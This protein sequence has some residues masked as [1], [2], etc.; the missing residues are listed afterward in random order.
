MRVIVI[1]AGIAGL[2]AA[3]TLRRRGIDVVVLEAAGSVGGRIQTATMKG[4]PVELGAQFLSTGYRVLPD[5]L[6]A[7]GLSSVP[8]SQ[9][10]AI[11]TGGRLRTITSTSTLSLFRSGLVS[12]ADVGAVARSSATLRRV[13]RLNRADLTS[14]ADHGGAAARAWA[15]RHVGRGVTE[16]LLEPTVNGLYFQALDASDWSLA[17]ALT[18]FWMRRSRAI[19]LPGGLGTL[20][21]AIADRLTV[22]TN[23]TVSDVTSVA[24][25]VV[26][27]TDDGRRYEADR[28]IVAVPGPVAE[29]IYPAASPLDVQL[30][31]VPYS[32]GLVVALRSG[33]RLPPTA[34]G[35]AYGVLVH[36]NEDSSL[37]AIAVASRAHPS[38]PSDGDAVTVMFNHDS[39][40]SFS[41]LD[42][43]SIAARALD[44]LERISPGL[45]CL[46]S[47][48]LVQRWPHAMPTVPPGHPARVADYR[49]HL[50]DNARIV[51]AGD[52][53]GFPWTDAAAHNGIWAADHI[54]RT[55]HR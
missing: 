23:T 34:L 29:T 48:L 17:G 41:Q 1:G 45:R 28:A 27:A 54:A 52:Y 9:R 47:P 40:I 10:S 20:P 26:A 42:D 16:T 15:E 36:P 51:L 30:M 31:R 6:G 5:L 22:E 55:S 43:R 12:P 4:V 14:W 38:C 33:A 46:L 24:N 50:P 7:S 39:A 18:G 49:E 13:S 32:C 35:G 37:A 8:I 44:A 19:T 2:S 25:G 21:H 53:L 3:W 11:L